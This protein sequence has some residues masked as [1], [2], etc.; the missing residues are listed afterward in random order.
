MAVQTDK[1]TKRMETL[2][3]VNKFDETDTISILRFLAQLKTACES[4][5]VFR[6]TALW[7]KTEFVNVEPLSSLTV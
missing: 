2:M 7:I 4:N 3:N 5:E 6:S 1:H